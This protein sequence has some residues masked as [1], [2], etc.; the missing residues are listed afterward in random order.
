M[1]DAR[2]SLPIGQRVSFP[3]HFDVPVLLEDARALGDAGSIGFDIRAHR[4]I[5]EHT[6]RSR[7]AASKLRD[8]LGGHLSS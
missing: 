6:G 3:G 5:D 1:P 2:F 8:T 7:C 4:V